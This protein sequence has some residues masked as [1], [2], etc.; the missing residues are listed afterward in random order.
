[1]FHKPTCKS[2]TIE[3]LEDHIAENM[4]DLAFGDDF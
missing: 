4:D 1:M 3:L 2:T